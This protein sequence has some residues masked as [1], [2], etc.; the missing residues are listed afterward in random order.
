VFINVPKFVTQMRNGYAAEN[1]VTV[2]STCDRFSSKVYATKS[3]WSP[4]MYLQLVTL[5]DSLVELLKPS[6]R[7]QSLALDHHYGFDGRE[8]AT[9]AF[10]E[11][12][13]QHNRPLG[14]IDHRRTLHLPE[15]GL[16]RAD[17]HRVALRPEFADNVGDGASVKGV[18]VIPQNQHTAFCR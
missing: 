7:E 1:G 18:A 5:G 16:G 12:S 8:N 17:V 11:K 2:C 4:E 15:V 9:R 6:I 10:Q 3:M 14:N 13:F